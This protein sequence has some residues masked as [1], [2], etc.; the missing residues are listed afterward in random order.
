MTKE[1]IKHKESD[2]FEPVQQYFESL[3]Y[4]VNGEVGNCDILAEKEGY[5][6]AV[7]MKLSLNLEVI[8]QAADRQRIVDGVYIATLRP[9][10]KI[11]LKKNSKVIHLL[12]RLELGLIYVY[13][14]NEQ[15][16]LEV[17]Q[18]A[19]PYDREK[20]RQMYKKKREKYQQELEKRVTLVKGGVNRTKLVTAYKEDAIRLAICL[21]KAGEASPKQ[22]A[23][24]KFT[25]VRI[26][27][28][29]SKN[30]YGWFRK[31]GKGIYSVSE[32][33]F[34]E[35]SNYDYISR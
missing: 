29:L 28:I 35:K 1:T 24:D 16:Y 11:A 34:A 14:E 2:L 30:Y 20:S 18:E 5:L 3:G 25:N 12:K 19:M 21:E 7:E 22:L 4:K 23:D 17:I 33:W 10:G 15:S 27:T 6:L 31:C 32:Q 13:F 8:L 26:Q 9:K